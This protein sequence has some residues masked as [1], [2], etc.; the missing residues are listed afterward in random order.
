M[1]SH[2]NRSQASED[3]E[4]HELFWFEYRQNSTESRNH[5]LS[6][7]FNGVRSIRMNLNYVYNILMFIMCD[8]NW[9]I[10]LSDFRSIFV[11]GFQN[12]LSQRYFWVIQWWNISTFPQLLFFVVTCFVHFLIVSLFL[13]VHFV[14]ALW[15]LNC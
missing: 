12:Y 2:L 1:K 6:T 5:R 8:S 13:G 4:P 7:N 9:I 14:T 15:K 10:Y 3:F 11:A